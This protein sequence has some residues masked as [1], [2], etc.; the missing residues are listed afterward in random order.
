VLRRLAQG[1]P[2]RE[3]AVN[4][5]NYVAAQQRNFVPALEPLIYI[6]AN[7]GLL[8]EVPHIRVAESGAKVRGAGLLIKAPCLATQLAPSPS[9]IF[10]SGVA[11]NESRL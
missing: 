6:D 10:S 9:A 5:K 4:R 7:P 11:P 3:H 8:C 1:T 2:D